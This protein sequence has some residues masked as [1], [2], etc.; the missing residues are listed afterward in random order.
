MRA[1]PHLLLIA[2]LLLL[3][4]RRRRRLLV[5]VRRVSSHL[6]DAHLGIAHL[7]V[8]HGHHTRHHRIGERELGEAEGALGMQGILV[9]L[10]AVAVEDDEVLDWL[11][12]L[13]ED[14]DD[15][16]G[17]LA[18]EDGSHRRGLAADIL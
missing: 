17:E 9:S 10:H 18:A 8:A 16:L 1:A 13:A 2:G 3:M 6:R 12:A 14:V 15:I 4:R 5:V 11:L 7:G